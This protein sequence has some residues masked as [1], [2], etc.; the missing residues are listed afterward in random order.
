MGKTDGK[1]APT[2]NLT[3]LRFVTVG[4]LVRMA[5]LP[6]VA[7]RCLRKPTRSILLVDSGN[8]VSA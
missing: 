8:T 1:G 4:K 3:A 2:P 5:L 6:A 7:D